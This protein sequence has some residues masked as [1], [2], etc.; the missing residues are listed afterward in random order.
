[1]QCNDDV[2]TKYGKYGTIITYIRNSCTAR[3]LTGFY[4][5]D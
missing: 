3:G 5:L 1:M 4:K 2:K